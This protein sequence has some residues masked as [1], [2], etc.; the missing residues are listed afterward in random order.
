MSLNSSSLFWYN[1]RGKKK[2][3]WMHQYRHFL[4][5]FE[6]QDSKDQSGLSLVY[7][8]SK[9]GWELFVFREGISKWVMWILK[10]IFYRT[11]WLQKIL[12]TLQRNFFWRGGEEGW[13]LSSFMYIL[14][15]YWWYCISV[16][17][18]T[19]APLLCFYHKLF[20]CH[21]VQEVIHLNGDRSVCFK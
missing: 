21:L 9:M 3:W 18:I 17:E 12:W 11:D 15:M 19:T 2:C 16:G 5:L 13:H 1:C 4:T 10:A 6:H 7:L 20:L 8:F 14:N